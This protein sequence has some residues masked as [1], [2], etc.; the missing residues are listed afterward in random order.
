MSTLEASASPLADLFAA[1]FALSLLPEE[2][3]DFDAARIAE[4]A[5]FTLAAAAQREGSAPAIA[6]ESISKAGSRY[7]RIAVINDDMPF[8]VDSIA[9]AITALGLA[10]DRLI[11]PVV[12]VRRDP[13]GA[14]LA[15]PEG[16]AI[17]ERR[18]SMVYLET[19][20]VDARVRRD[21]AEALRATLAD[22]HAAVADWPRMQAAMQEDARTLADQEGAALL[23]WLADGMLTQ[24]GH[25][26]RRRDGTSD[27][28][29]GMCRASAAPL[30]AAGTLGQ[31]RQGSVQAAAGQGQ[32][33]FQQGQHGAQIG[34]LRQPIRPAP[35][36]GFDHRGADA[37]LLGQLAQPQTPAF[38]GLA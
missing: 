2:A 30:L 34:R 38:A 8:L 28:A 13:A 21:L 9:G 4:A 23:R 31:R 22:V 33:A 5:R 36:E 18:E 27:A 25:V 16:E 24:L 19:E 10:I 35:L 29:L 20:R 1:R 32:V 12:A 7:L 15:M 6:I 37:G 3:V 26:V 14:L 11:H 17:G